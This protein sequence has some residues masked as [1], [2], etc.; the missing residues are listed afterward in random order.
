MWITKLNNLHKNFGSSQQSQLFCWWVAGTRH[1]LNPFKIN[2]FSVSDCC[3]SLFCS[4]RVIIIHNARH[5]ISG[6][7]HSNIV[8]FIDISGETV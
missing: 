7:T 4:Q 2:D 5:L 3:G 1:L 8:R 6:L